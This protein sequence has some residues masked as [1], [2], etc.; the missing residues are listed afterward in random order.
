MNR[1]ISLFF[2]WFVLIEGGD[3]FQYSSVLAPM[4]WEYMLL[5]NFY[6]KNVTSKNFLLLGA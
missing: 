6:Y 4:K 2:G 5:L 1:N 3:A